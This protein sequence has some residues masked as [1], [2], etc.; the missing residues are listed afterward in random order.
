MIEAMK[1]KATKARVHGI[2]S[3]GD[4]EATM[5]LLDIEFIGE[6]VEDYTYHNNN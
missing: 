3:K 2:G 4:Q 6:F 5:E 1:E